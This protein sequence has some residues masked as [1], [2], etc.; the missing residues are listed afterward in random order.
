MA[1]SKMAVELQILDAGKVEAIKDLVNELLDTI[2]DLRL[3]VSASNR[4]P[5]WFPKGDEDFEIN[6]IEKERRKYIDRF[7]S[8]ITDET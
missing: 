7:A 5:E 2:R 1:K 4:D 8:I 6:E 3:V